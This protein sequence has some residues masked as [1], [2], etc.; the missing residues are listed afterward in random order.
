MQMCV[1]YRQPNK[2]NIIC[3]ELT[4]KETSTVYWIIYIYT[5]VHHGSPRKRW[6]TMGQSLLE[7]KLWSSMEKKIARRKPWN[8]S[9]SAWEDCSWSKITFK[10]T[11]HLQL[12]DLQFEQKTS[13]RG[14]DPKIW[15][16][17]KAK[18]QRKRPVGSRSSTQVLMQ[19]FRLKDLPS[20]KEGQTNTTV[21]KHVS[22][23]GTYFFLQKSV[24]WGSCWVS[25]LP[26]LNC[27][28]VTI[29]KTNATA[30]MMWK[31][32]KQLYIVTLCYTF[33]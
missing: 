24:S 30:S 22:F 17:F 29:C 11:K 23:F 27:F 5:E 4:H 2:K 31:K 7:N 32:M 20:R 10:I 26:K 9:S 12:N 21:P 13:W 1:S 33:Y 18:S 16:F 6:F 25:N 14:K 28:F 15:L 19:D 8:K 3:A